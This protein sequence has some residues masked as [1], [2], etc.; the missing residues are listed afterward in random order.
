MTQEIA[1]FMEY[2]LLEEID[3]DYS[4]ILVDEDGQ[5]ILATVN[6]LMN[7]SPETAELLVER[8]NAEMEG[9]LH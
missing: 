6:G 5:W 9:N 3:E 7:I 4:E 8:W 1:N 2:V